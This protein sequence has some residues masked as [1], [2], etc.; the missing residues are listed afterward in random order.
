MDAKA[1]AQLRQKLV[2]DDAFRAEFA[3]SPADAL[4]SLGVDLPPEMNP[5]PLDKNELDTRVEELKDAAGDD[6]ES[7][8]DPGVVAAEILEEGGELPDDALEQVA[9]GVG[10]RAPSRQ[11]RGMGLMNFTRQLN[12]MQFGGPQ[13]PSGARP[14]GGTF[15]GTDY[16]LTVF[17]EVDW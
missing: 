16:S 12:R 17:G 11:L 8:F 2:E 15:G 9:G 7:V 1:I 6:L 10:R 13:R 14:P 5:P 3:A 4:R